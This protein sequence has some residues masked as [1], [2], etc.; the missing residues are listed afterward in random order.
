M[1]E[2]QI[3]KLLENGKSIN[4]A[5]NE[6]GIE[7][8]FF[9]GHLLPLYRDLQRWLDAYRLNFAMQMLFKMCQDGEGTAST[10]ISAQKEIIKI[11]LEK[12]SDGGGVE[13]PTINIKFK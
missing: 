7:E 4:D 11:L 2:E 3:I 1:K 12:G 13:A 9:L 5:L 8:A 10:R 6:L